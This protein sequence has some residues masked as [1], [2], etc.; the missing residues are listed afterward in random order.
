M[1]KRISIQVLVENTASGH[2]ML[3]EHG[4]AFWIDTGACRLLFDTG[5]GLAAVLRNNADKLG[6]RL[7]RTDV[8][9][10]SHGHF[11]HTGG[12]PGV[13]TV[14]YAPGLYA[15]PAAFDAK[16][17][18]SDDGAARQIGIPSLS[19]AAVEEERIDGPIWTDKPTEV[20]EGVWVTGEVPRVTDFEDTGGP[21]FL[22]EELRRPDPLV[23]DQAVFFESA[24]GTVVLLGCAHA[25]VINTLLHVRQLTGNRP[26]HTLMGGMHLGQASRTRMQRTVEAFRQLN[27]KRLGPAHCTGRTATAELWSAFPGRCFPCEVGA[28]LE[29]Q[30]R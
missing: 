19:K 8:I 24:E 18:R 17:V 5:Q 4:L 3:A 29:F 28:S 13:L 26:V 9:V 2:G 11:D 12:L 23:D 30:G 15:H 25:G 14:T 6:V 1:G 20:C 22:D 27:I 21:F 16:Y 10:L 7:E